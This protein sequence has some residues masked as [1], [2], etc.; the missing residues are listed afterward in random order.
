MTE[1]TDIALE[2]AEL[3]DA[4]RIATNKSGDDFLAD[5]F[6]VE[7]GS[8]EFFQIIYAVVARTAAL[9]RILVE[10]GVSEPVLE[11]ARAHL[12]E[13]RSAFDRTSQSQPWK[14]IGIERVGSAHS[15]AIRML[16][17]GISRSHSYRRL[18]ENELSDV[19]ATAEQLIVWLKDH[20][21]VERD[22][23]RQNLIDGLESFAFRLSKLKW[24]GLGY[25]LE[26]LN[27]VMAAYLALERGLDLASNPDAGAAIKKIGQGMAKILKAA[28]VLKDSAE[29]GEWVYGL[30]RAGAA[31][32][33]PFVAGYLTHGS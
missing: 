23:I 12:R 30:L 5:E 7:K 10:E 16:S 22:F 2:L 24:F 33:G 18:S 14:S 15:S 6:A 21:I 26:T 31:Y 19:L 20:Q 25:S 17:L 27:S 3:C 32:G 29:V 1:Q 4:L 28:G 9:E 8:A 11:G 13:I